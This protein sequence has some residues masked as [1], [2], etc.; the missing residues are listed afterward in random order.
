[1]RKKSKNLHGKFS[2]D[3]KSLLAKIKEGAALLVVRSEAVG[4]P[5]FLRMRNT[6]LTTR[7]KEVEKENG[8]L[9]EQARKTSPGADSPLRKR[10]VERRVLATTSADV[11]NTAALRE[12]TP[13]NAERE[14]F[15]P[16]PQR[17]PR[18]KI[19][20]TAAQRAPPPA[21]QRYT[22]AEDTE[23]ESYLTQQ[24][25]LLLA[26]RNLERDR[27]RREGQ[28]R[29]WTSGQENGNRTE[30]RKRMEKATEGNRKKTGARIIS[31]V[32][33]VPPPE[34]RLMEGASTSALSASETD[35]KVAA[36]GR[37]RRNRERRVMPPPPP[38]H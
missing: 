1:M 25:N 4:D 9:K 29:I 10:K 15:P 37:R 34:A 2:G 5:Q 7:L 19:G 27:K 28:K 24:I 31:D 8:W 3:M 33:V 17:T 35:W 32:R 38:P 12:M 36:G 20:E 11:E 16:L 23:A 13:T 14:E 26:A 21:V 30:E 22:D 18:N 6:E